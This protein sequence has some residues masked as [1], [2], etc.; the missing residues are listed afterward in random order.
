MV[1]TIYSPTQERLLESARQL[2]CREGIHAT[3]VAR[4]LSE[5]GV[6][7]R[8]LYESFGS[9]ESLLKAVFEREAAMWFEW[10]DEE[11]PRRANT[12][13]SQILALFD[14]LR[15]WFAS[16]EF[17]GCL[18]TNAV[19]EH[20]REASWVRDLAVSHFARVQQ[21]V[22]QLA[23]SMGAADAVLTARQ[24]C[25]LVDGAIATAMVSHDPTSADLAQSIARSVLREAMPES[26]RIAQRVLA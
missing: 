26:T 14:V 20:D 8:T 25:L 2:F 3:G 17:F 7:R 15:E 16:G 24:L 23:R 19:A 1:A 13:Q 6:A 11:L 4:I 10:F 5:A 18:F 9:K 21:R 12:P 22:E